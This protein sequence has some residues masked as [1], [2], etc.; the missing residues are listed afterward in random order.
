MLLAAL[1]AV[2]GSG[3]VA[4]AGSFTVNSFNEGADDDLGDG[5]CQTS[6]PG[7]CTFRAAIAEANATDA[8]STI[9]L[10]AGTYNITV[11]LELLGQSASRDLTLNGDGSSVT[12]ISSPSSLALGLIAGATV[13]ISGLTVQGR[14]SGGNGGGIINPGGTLTLTD[15]TVKNNN[16]INGGGIWNSG[17]LTIK[18]STIE[19]NSASGAGAGIWNHANGIVNISTSTIS[20]NV[21]SN[22]PKQIEGGGVY[23][24]G[25]VT[26]NHT[27]VEFNTAVRGGGIENRGG[28]TVNNSDISF[29]L[30]N[31]GAGIINHSFGTMT[32]SKS[33]VELNTASNQGGGIQN[34][35]TM[36]VSDSVIRHN[37]ALHGAG[38]YD[39]GVGTATLE[40]TTI[41][42]NI[43]AGRGGGIE[44]AGTMTL[45]NSTVSLNTA[46][47]DGGGIFNGFNF[48]SL[49][50]VNSTVSG[51]TTEDSGG[52]IANGSNGNLTLASTIIAGNMAAVGPDCS[53]A[54][55]T[56][57][58]Y[59]LIG[60]TASCVFAQGPLGDLFN[61]D[62]NLGDLQDN[63]GPTETHAV[64]P[65][66]PAHD[67]IPAANCTDVGGN[68]VTTDQR[69]VARPQGT[70]CDIG[71]YEGPQTGSV[72]NLSQ[73]GLIAMAVS[74]G[75]AVVILTRRRLALS[76]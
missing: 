18:N 32:T 35:G 53:G 34:D 33:T 43:A 72:P 15:V 12:V 68:P 9:T 24:E 20:A 7:E 13:R 57:E 74:L 10:A 6:T 64:L 27:T 4:H 69:G 60:N 58:S 62:P 5:V 3:S 31:N 50:L 44:T 54:D 47:D 23:S 65:G 76:H 75:A 21:D 66:S 19:N 36:T 70:G 16:A 37:T 71:A 61:V 40:R 67:V 38:I 22:E 26:L 59:N 41:N 52:G 48:N 51:N 39:G 25:S 45:I 63:G 55:P 46:V 56:S 14:T 42:T 1:L 8:A 73:W 30:A 2:F 17:T 11:G 28:L 49:T 29:N